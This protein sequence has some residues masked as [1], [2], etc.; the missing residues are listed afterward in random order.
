[1]Q[2]RLS[3]AIGLVGLLAAIQLIGAT[4]AAAFCYTIKYQLLNLY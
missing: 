2:Q 3:A 4:L 1:L